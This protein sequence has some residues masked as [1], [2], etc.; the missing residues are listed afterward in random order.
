MVVGVGSRKVRVRSRVKG[1]GKSQAKANSELLMEREMKHV[2]VFHCQPS[3]D[4]FNS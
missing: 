2:A 1:Y 4:S 3:L